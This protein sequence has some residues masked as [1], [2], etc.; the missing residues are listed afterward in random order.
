[1]NG[2][3]L[4]LA[5]VLTVEDDP[6]LLEFRC[7]HTAVL[8]WP[9]VR[10]M[11]LRTVMSDLMYRTP[12]VELRKSAAPP[13]GRALSTMGRSVLN[14]AAY[15]LNGRCRAPVCIMTDGISNRLVEG[16]WFN[17]LSD[18]FALAMP[19]QTLAIE[20]HFDWQWPTPR[21]FPRVMYH[22]PRQACNVVAG[23]LLVRERHRRRAKELVQLVSQ[24]AQ[25]H[26]GW[27]IGSG[28]ARLLA[29][30]LARK[31]AAMP[32]QYRAYASML[33]R[34]SPRILLINMGCYGPS[35]TLV[36]AARE[37]D[38][39]TA[40]YQHGAV[41]SGHDAYNLAPALRDSQDYRRTLPDHF[42]AFG[43]WWAEQIN[44]PV[45]KIA[46]GNPH[47]E[48]QLATLQRPAH[49]GRDILLL[50]DGIEA[51]KYLELARQL[52]PRVAGRD[53]RVVFRPHPIER[54]AVE[55]AFGSGT[56]GVAIDPNP[57]I[58]ASLA[59]AHAVVSEQSSGLFEAV[60]L[61]SRVFVWNT[62]KSRFGLPSHPFRTAD[63][64]DHLAALLDD[65]HAGTMAREATA[66]IW[67]T[68]WR[69][70]Y[71]QFLRTCGVE[72]QRS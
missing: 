27:E 26:L 45:S 42:L 33:K 65:P 35:A 48:A 38:V 60:G 66:A 10:T 2:N 46:L 68:D 30:T 64:A 5:D 36:A 55:A 16:R 39:K 13:L 24:R 69:A 58:Y 72:P 6:A 63:S 44:M 9:Y 28:R 20:D 34:V 41:S 7:A 67:A 71:E 70:N 49:A 3:E 54:P 59:A 56:D 29:T 12:L 4:K 50:G 18:Y 51:D 43:A 14:N 11:F 53:L 19:A 31:L 15:R 61:A 37:Q 40:E 52:V 22:A 57:D 32:L 47:R 8:L 1:M 62:A 17:R 21:H 25:T 23:R